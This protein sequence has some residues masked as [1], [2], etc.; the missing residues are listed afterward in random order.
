MPHGGLRVQQSPN[1]ETAYALGVIRNAKVSPS[2][3]VVESLVIRLR[4]CIDTLAPRVKGVAREILSPEEP[5]LAAAEEAAVIALYR[6]KRLGPGFDLESGFRYCQRLADSIE[7]LL[8][9]EKGLVQVVAGA[10][11]AGGDSTVQT[12]EVESASS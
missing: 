5:Q 6:A 2:P 8:R 9:I 4:R 11:P 10:S 1:A 3:A 7:D 12:D